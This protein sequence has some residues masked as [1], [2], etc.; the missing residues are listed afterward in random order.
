M[1]QSLT[2]NFLFLHDWKN[3]CLTLNKD[4]QSFLVLFQSLHIKTWWCHHV[5]RTHK[6]QTLHSEGPWHFSGSGFKIDTFQETLQTEAKTQNLSKSLVF[7]KL[8]CNCLLVHKG[9]DVMHPYRECSIISFYGRLCWQACN[10]QLLSGSWVGSSRK[11]EASPAPPLPSD[12]LAQSSSTGTPIA[13]C[14]ASKVRCKS[15][16]ACRMRAIW[17][18]TERTYSNPTLAFGQRMRSSLV[19]GS[20]NHWPWRSMLFYTAGSWWCYY[21]R[22]GSSVNEKYI[23]FQSYLYLR[24]TSVKRSFEGGGGEEEDEGGEGEGG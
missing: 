23:F 4:F 5:V 12:G 13:R 14:F 1:G 22:P 16:K 20:I 17:K 19:R 24:A 15:F 7:W 21:W 8:M 10:F 11:G 9:H 3:K 6:C 18:I 2:W